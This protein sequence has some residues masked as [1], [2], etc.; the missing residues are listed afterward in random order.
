MFTESMQTINVEMFL[1]LINV[2]AL[3]SYSLLLVY[4]PHPPFKTMWSI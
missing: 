4:W 2:Q 3:Y 1:Y